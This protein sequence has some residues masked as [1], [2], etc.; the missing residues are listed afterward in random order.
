MTS[1]TDA[2]ATA[3]GGNLSDESRESALRP[4]AKVASPATSPGRT[5]LIHNLIHMAKFPSQKD[6]H[7]HPKPK[8][9]SLYIVK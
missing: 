3:E 4:A 1:I 6:S 5:P 9:H 7:Y 2:T 8:Q